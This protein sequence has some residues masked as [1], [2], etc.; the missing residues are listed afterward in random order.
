MGG[1]RDGAAKVHRRAGWKGAGQPPGG[2]PPRGAALPR[3]GMGAAAERAVGSDEGEVDPWAPRLVLSGP[4]PTAFGLRLLPSVLPMADPS[5][6]TPHLDFTSPR[7]LLTEETLG[8]DPILAFQRWLAEAGTTSGMTYPNAVA[9]STVDA[10]GRPDG[11]IVLLKGADARGFT[12]FTNFASAKGRALE[13]NPRAALTFYWDRLGRQVRARGGVERV[14]DAESDAYFASR[15]RVSRIGAWASEQSRPLSSRAD[16]EAR[17]AELEARHPGDEIPRPPHWGG[18]LLRP[19][20]VEFWQ[21][22]P[23]RLH[24]RIRFRRE[25]S[26]WVTDRLFP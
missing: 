17:V 12:F 6:P 18:F 16:L 14:P 7:P 20:E 24:D 15:P 23:F 3:S 21:E 25:G 5:R 10:D 1:R 8:G 19:T 13:A 22:G 11:R 26:G 9:L 2:S 4:V